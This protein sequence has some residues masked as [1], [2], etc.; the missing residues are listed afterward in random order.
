MDTAEL[1]KKLNVYRQVAAQCSQTAEQ[2][3]QMAFKNIGAAEA[4]EKLINEITAADAAQELPV[5]VDNE[6]S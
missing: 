3:E 4:I 5:E 1:Q 2:Y 6:R